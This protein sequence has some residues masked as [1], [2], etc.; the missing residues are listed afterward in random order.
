MM[1]AKKPKTAVYTLIAVLLIAAL[2]VGCTFT[3]AKAPEVTEPT[4]SREKTE[5]TQATEEPDEEKD[6]LLALGYTNQELVS[7]P[8]LNTLPGQGQILLDTEI[9]YWITDE[10]L[11]AIFKDLYR[12]MEALPGE[13]AGTVI[14]GLTDQRM[15][16]L[17]PFA[18]YKVE[19]YILLDQERAIHRQEF[20][21]FH[22]DDQVEGNWTYMDSLT[23]TELNAYKTSELGDLVAAIPKGEA[24]ARYLWNQQNP[25]APV[26]LEWVSAQDL[27][28]I[29]QDQE[30]L[31]SLPAEYDDWYG[32]GRLRHIDES[33]W[34]DLQEGFSERLNVGAV[35][36]DMELLYADEELRVYCYK[37]GFYYVVDREDALRCEYYVAC[38]YDDS[39][40]EEN[41]WGVALRSEYELSFIDTPELIAQYGSKEAAFANL[42]LD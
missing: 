9:G 32:D 5:Q 41:R 2:A 8:E 29:P 13:N 34:N 17:L 6:A 12:Q 37:M 18:V 3:S 38:H 20:A 10:Q 11:E 27:P 35:I 40:P 16:N 33:L 19:Y 42:L 4:E 36:T 22:Y 15:S 26:N 21:L 25:E 14:T 7:A 31:T 39:Y 30:I 1:I 23:Q 28:Q 24:V